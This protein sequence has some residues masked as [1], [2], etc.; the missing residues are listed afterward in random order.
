MTTIYRGVVS[1]KTLDKTKKPLVTWPWNFLKRGKI[2]NN[3]K[4]ENKFFCKR[5]IKKSFWGGGGALLP[6]IPNM[7]KGN[8]QS[9]SQSIFLLRKN[10][11]ENLKTSV[12]L[13][14][15]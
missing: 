8:P 11:T 9:W 7:V 5:V 6:K 3:K 14:L 4:S 2:D 10:M 15:I 13:S 1:Y 12:K